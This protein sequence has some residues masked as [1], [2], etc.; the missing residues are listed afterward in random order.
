MKNSRFPICLILFFMQFSGVFA[1]LIHTGDSA[2]LVFNEM[3]AKIQDYDD[4][5]DWEPFE[6]ITTV[7]YESTSKLEKSFLFDG[8]SV[9]LNG[10]I[11]AKGDTLKPVFD[12]VMPWSEDKSLV[13]KN[14]ANNDHHEF[15]A[16]VIDVN[17]KASEVYYLEQGQH[18]VMRKNGKWGMVGR[19]DLSEEIPFEY[20]EMKSIVGTWKRNV[21]GKKSTVF[22]VPAKKK[23]KWGL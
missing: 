14:F 4:S 21:D 19:D 6:F 11:N 1:Q 5:G 12:G 15:W 18:I 16:F 20:E 3:Y 10:L 22:S 8:F 9:E 13:Y 17:Y 2:Q 23:G 7:L